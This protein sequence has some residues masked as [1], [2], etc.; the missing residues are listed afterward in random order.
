MG[1]LGGLLV[2]G[3][4]F[5]ALGEGV[6]INQIFQVFATFD[7]CGIGKLAGAITGRIKGL[8]ATHADGHVRPVEVTGPL[9]LVAQGNWRDA[10]LFAVLT[11]LLHHCEE[12]GPGLGDFDTGIFEDGLVVP[13]A[14]HAELPHRG[15]FFA[16]K[17]K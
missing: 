13:H 16:I 17:C 12:I 8:F 6:E 9:V 11:Q 7:E 14:D 15:V 5:R 3:L 2:K 1:H 10:F 4:G